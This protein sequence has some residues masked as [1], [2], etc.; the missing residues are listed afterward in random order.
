MIPEVVVVGDLEMFFFGMTFAMGF[1]SAARRILGGYRKR[2]D[3]KEG[4]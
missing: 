2:R 3:R 4:Q 1:P